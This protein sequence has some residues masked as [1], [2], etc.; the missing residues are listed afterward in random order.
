[1]DIITKNIGDLEKLCLVYNVEK[2]YLFGS[3]LTP[4][5]NKK[6]DIDLLVKFKKIEL[7]GYF[8]NYMNLKEKLTQLFGRDVDLV[9]EQTLK[10]PILIQSINKSKELVYG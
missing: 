7:S 1:M 4:A 8:D 2:L 5:F 3:A 9:E 6:S 10:N